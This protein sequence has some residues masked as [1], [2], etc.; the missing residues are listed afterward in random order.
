MS[1]HLYHRVRWRLSPLWPAQDREPQA[2]GEWSAM[3]GWLWDLTEGLPV[4][5][6]RLQN[7]AFCTCQSRC[8][9]RPKTH[10]SGYLI[11][12]PLTCQGPKLLG[13]TEP[14]GRK[15]VHPPSFSSFHCHCPSSFSSFLLSFFP[16]SLSTG[17]SRR[18]PL[19]GDA[20]T[21]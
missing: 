11:L 5:G 14:E 4:C 18:L 13:T 2:S 8:N 12:S 16:Q 15:G 6:G 1:R 19:S 7:M 3:R 9:L 17:V 10:L 21:P 20:Q